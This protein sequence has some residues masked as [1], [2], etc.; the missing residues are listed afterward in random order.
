MAERRK[1][2]DIKRDRK[3]SEDTDGRGR[4]RDGDREIVQDSEINRQTDRHIRSYGN[5]K[6][7]LGDLRHREQDRKKRQER[8]RERRKRAH[9]T[10]PI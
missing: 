5:R 8:E 3:L 6:R 9:V 7:A 4:G 10:P 1:L 2:Q